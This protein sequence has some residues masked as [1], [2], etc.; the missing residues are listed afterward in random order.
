METKLKLLLFMGAKINTLGKTVC[1]LPSDEPL[2]QAA[3]K[4]YCPSEFF[5]K[6]RKITLK[7]SYLFLQNNN[8]FLGASRFFYHLQKYFNYFC[9]RKDTSNLSKFHSIKQHSPLERNNSDS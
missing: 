6:N 5:L 3:P 8:H 1:W 7:N 4:V 9:K 2:S